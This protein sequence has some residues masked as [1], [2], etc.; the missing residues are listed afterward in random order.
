MQY[1][2]QLILTGLM[3]GMVYALVAVGIVLIFKSS[4]VFNF[5]QG[6]FMLV[7]GYIG[8]MFAVQ[9]GLNIWFSILLTLISLFA[10]GL[11]IERL[12]L[13]G[14]IGKPIFATITMTIGISYILRGG[15]TMVWW[16]QSRAYPPVFPIKPLQLGFLRLPQEYIYIGVV[17][18]LAIAIFMTVY[19]YTRLGLHMMATAE[20]HQVSQS[21][22]INVKRVFSLSWGIS[23]LI[24]A[25]AAVLL[26]AVNGINAS[27]NFFGMKAFPVVILGGAES[28]MGALVGGLIIGVTEYLA[29]GLVD[30]LL[31][32]FSLVTPFLVLMIF[33]LFRPFGLFGLA[34]IE[35]I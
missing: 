2:L 34:K 19:R 3:V 24:A 17:S 26:A 12:F 35:R 31:P 32:G 27:F 10:L 25:V 16:G 9:F 18:L 20:D 33:I 15:T 14:M 5:A 30:P 11:G 8:W 23:A 29:I 21:L 22:G 13:R 28:I 6:E 4:G 1:I 7:G